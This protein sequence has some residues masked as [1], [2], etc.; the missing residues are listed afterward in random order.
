MSNKSDPFQFMINNRKKILNEIRSSGSIPKAWN[1][2]IK[3]IPELERIAKFNTFKG[4]MKA[5][6]VVDEI[7]DK[8]NEICAEKKN[9]EVE[10]DTVRQD[11]E[12]KEKELGK[13]RQEHEIILKQLLKIQAE[14]TEL[15]NELNMVS[16]KIPN[17]KNEPKTVPK[18]V[19]GWG[20]QLKGNYYRLFKRING[21]VKWIHVGRTWKIDLAERKIRE[22]TG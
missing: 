2:L 14:K 16:Q 10:L 20:V 18:H 22:F 21:K 12:R 9:L 13:V 8:K 1:L 19:N 11:K 17:P 6:Y 4:Y 3:K 15:E 5:L 7:M